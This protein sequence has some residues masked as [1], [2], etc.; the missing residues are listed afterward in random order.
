M[1]VERASENIDQSVNRAFTYLYVKNR[2]GRFNGYLKIDT[3]F[4]KI[5]AILFYLLFFTVKKKD[6]K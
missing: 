4:Y 5:L 2:F 6:S 3:R 1:N